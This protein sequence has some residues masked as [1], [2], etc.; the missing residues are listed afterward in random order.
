MIKLYVYEVWC[1]MKV[2]EVRIW[3]LIEVYE[4]RSMVKEYEVRS[5]LCV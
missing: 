3:C 2:Y 5:K 1:M 4:V